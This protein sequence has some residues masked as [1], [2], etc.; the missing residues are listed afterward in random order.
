MC[1]TSPIKRGSPVESH[2]IARRYGDL[3]SQLKAS[4]S[5]VQ[6]MQSLTDQLHAS[7]EQVTF[8]CVVSA[9]SCKVVTHPGCGRKLV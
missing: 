5:E 7:L 3:E 8:L 2:Q 1:I 6:Q 9:R 4:Q